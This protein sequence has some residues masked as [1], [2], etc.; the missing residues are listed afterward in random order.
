MKITPLEPVVNDVYHF[1]VPTG[2]RTPTR[3]K[4]AQV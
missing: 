4:Y 2:R 1:T 3:L